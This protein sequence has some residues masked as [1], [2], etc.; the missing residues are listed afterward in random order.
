[1]AKKA[2]SKYQEI[3]DDLTERMQTGRY[4]E[5]DRL[6]TEMELAEEYGVSRPTVVKAME[7][8]R[9]AGL[10][11]RIQGKGTF[12]AGGAGNARAKIIS[13][14]LPFAQ[15]RDAARLDET[16][17]L[18]GIERRLS[19]R[20]YYT[21]LHYCKD[22][23]E[24]FLRVIGEARAAVSVGIIAYVAKDLMK[25]PD[26]YGLFS[27]DHPMVLIDQPIIGSPLPC[28]RSDNV[29]GGELAVQHLRE[30]GYPV[31][32]FLSDVNISFNESVRER[33]VGFCEEI[34]E[35]S[36]RFTYCH[37][38]LG[39]EQEAPLAIEQTLRQLVRDYPNKR[40]GLFCTGDY[41]ARRVYRTCRDLGLSVPEQIG[42][43]GF[44]GLGLPLS[45]ERRLTTVAQD[46]YQIGKLA[47]EA[48]ICQLETPH[49]MQ[50]TVKA[51]VTLVPGD[52]TAPEGA[53]LPEKKG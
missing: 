40:I 7:F 52:T 38:L 34:R 15:Y 29:S 19:Q 37:R 26:I 41:F 12:A 50:D 42:I 1:M 16:N 51:K 2:P 47:A 36:G 33:Y 17:I 32:C 53:V 20:G 31:I 14:V 23:G 46:F 5:H 25:C 22:N 9:N 39:S 24:D 11:Y 18:K 8:L 48:S 27:T 43:V 30:C 21:M 6:P 45:G 4:H 35:S 3:V 10:V 44:D 49:Q 13:V 28:V